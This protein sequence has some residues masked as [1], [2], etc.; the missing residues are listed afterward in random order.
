M[1]KS[2]GCPLACDLPRAE[3]EGAAGGGSGGGGRS[4]LLLGLGCGPRR[5]YARVQ[6]KLKRMQRMAHHGM[7]PL[8]VCPC[9]GVGIDVGSGHV[10]GVGAGES[11]WRVRAERHMHVWA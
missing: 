5:V 6:D 4:E 7:C 9:V 1:L 2:R 3:R 10:R 8:G 11:A